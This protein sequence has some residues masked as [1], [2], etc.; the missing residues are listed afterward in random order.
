[1]FDSISKPQGGT[2]ELVGAL[3]CAIQAT[4]PEAVAIPG[5]SGWH[6]FAALD[7][8]TANKVPVIVMSESTAHDEPRTPWKEWIKR[9]YV[10]LC[11]AALVGGSRHAQYMSQL[12][13]RPEIIFYGYDVIDNQYFSTAADEI[14]SMAKAWRQRLALPKRYFLASAR[15]MPKKNL[16][17]L[18]NAYADYRSVAIAS[19]TIPNDLWELVLL[20]EGE[21][22]EQLQ[23]LRSQRGLADCVHFPGFKQ[24][25]ELPPYYALAD[26]F[27]H[28]S[29]VEPWGL[30]VNEAMA[31]GLPL[32]VST[33]CG[34][35]PELV[36]EGQNGRTFDPHDEAAITSNMLEMARLGSEERQKMGFQSRQ[37][38]AG[39]GPERF[40]E[41]LVAAAA[42]ALSSRPKD[43]R[44]LSR[45][46][47]K[48]LFQ[49]SLARRRQSA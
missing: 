14:R 46:V 18:L 42:A 35:A 31:S 43:A 13:M 40:G 33:P 25:D 48:S 39:Y 45:V 29:S 34:C 17:R 28:A 24:Y 26:A 49:G 23:L 44:L 37:L 1:V 20:G 19:G 4:N 41:G 10:G 2:R 3:I 36:H 12:G 11:G 32:L 5:W 9:Q 22:Q 21:L 6:A 7:W 15:F 27:I 38:I 16:A 47:L 8:C 30:V